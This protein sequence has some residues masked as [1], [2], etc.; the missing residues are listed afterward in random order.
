M[1]WEVFSITQFLGA[2]ILEDADLTEEFEGKI[3]HVC[4]GMV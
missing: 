1:D 4:G 3:V 2:K